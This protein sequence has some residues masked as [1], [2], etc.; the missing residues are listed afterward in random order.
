MTLCLPIVNKSDM[1]IVIGFTVWSDPCS[2]LNFGL[3]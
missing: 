1:L 3:T 2:N